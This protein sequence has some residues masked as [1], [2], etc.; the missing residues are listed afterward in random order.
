[1]TGLGAKMG[2]TQRHSMPFN[3]KC[4]LHASGRMSTEARYLPGFSL[5]CSNYWSTMGVWAERSV[6]DLVIGCFGLARESVSPDRRRWLASPDE[7]DA[8]KA[9]KG[10]TEDGALCPYPGPADRTR[11]R[12]P[13]A[14]S[15]AILV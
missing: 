3:A 6:F 5:F 15:S 13:A 2:Q 8:R 12:S 4:R 1:M 11:R 14:V 9:A 7:G 10:S